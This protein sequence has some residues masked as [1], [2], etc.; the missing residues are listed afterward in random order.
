MVAGGQVDRRQAH[1]PT[2]LSRLQ[3]HRGDLELGSGRY[4][5]RD[6]TEIKMFDHPPFSDVMARSEVTQAG[7]EGVSMDRISEM[8]IYYAD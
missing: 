8:L 2:H 5:I 3:F 4:G 6:P 1:G 7:L